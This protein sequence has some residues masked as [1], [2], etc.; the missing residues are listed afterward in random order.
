MKT[1]HHKISNCILQRLKDDN[2]KLFMTIAS[3]PKKSIANVRV[4]CGFVLFQ[5]LYNIAY[6]GHPTKE[7]TGSRHTGRVFK[8]QQAASVFEGRGCDQSVHPLIHSQSHTLTKQLF[9]NKN[10]IAC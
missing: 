2:Q 4:T 10:E 5:S 1:C 9:L 3:P 7:S 8:R 6:I